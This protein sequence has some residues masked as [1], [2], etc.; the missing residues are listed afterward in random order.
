MV[1]NSMILIVTI[2]APVGIFPIKE[3]IM[4]NIILI[5]AIIMAKIIVCWKL[6]ETCKLELAGRMRRAD[7]NNAPA[8]LILIITVR[9]VIIEN[10]IS[11][12]DTGNPL[13]LACSALN[14]IATNSW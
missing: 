3:I 11:N 13:I 10:I 5:R 14:E 1:K 7:T 6:F 9:A 4:P 8:N 2:V 12:L